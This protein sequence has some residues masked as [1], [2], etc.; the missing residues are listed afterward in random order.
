[1]LR[2]LAVALLLPLFAGCTDRAGASGDARYPSPNAAVPSPNDLRTC[3][4]E[5]GCY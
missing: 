4:R 2:I 3:P 1:M 5:A